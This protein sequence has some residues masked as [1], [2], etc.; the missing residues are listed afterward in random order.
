MSRKRLKVS[1]NILVE[2]NIRIEK[3]EGTDIVVVD[4]PRADRMNKPVFLNGNPIGN[5]YRRNFE[6]DYRCSQEEY[7]AMVRDSG[8][9]LRSLDQAPLAG[10]SMDDLDAG[11][12][13]AYR[14]T[15]SAVRPGHPWLHLDVEEFLLRLGALAKSD[16]GDEVLATRAGLL[17][18]G[19]EWRITAEF[20]YYFLDYREVSDGPRRWEHRIVSG[21]GEWSGNLFDFWGLAWRRLSR[22]AD[23]PFGL[24]ERARRVE[25]TPLHAALR[26]ALANA[27]VHA[28][29]YVR[30]GT[31]VVR[32]DDSVEF[33]NPGCLRIP[34]DVAMA[35]GISDSRNPTLLK[36]FA[37][38]SI[39]ERAGSGFDTM[40]SGC[41]WAGLPDPELD[42]AF[43]PDRTTLTLR[44]AGEAAAPS[45]AVSS[46]KC[47]LGFWDDEDEVEKVLS[48][49]RERGWVSRVQ[50]ESRL[51]VGS[52]KAKKL[53]AELVDKGIAERRGAGRA[54]RYVPAG[55]AGDLES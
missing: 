45:G 39:V 50:V 20:P 40:R 16:R 8:I 42:E 13:S 30:G 44:I 28:D 11:A 32:R 53:L 7:Q 46:E 23:R 22:A 5:T 3:V 15:L 49:M 54:T 37:L 52:T 21:D 55:E 12:V 47:G 26:E 10:F 2:E 24:D 25:N 31:V 36:M 14:N 34:A 17:M 9:G 48:L 35:G 38:I 33:S 27:L 41:D 19:H 51:K 18:F 29:Y 4:V 43:D 1:A 6:G